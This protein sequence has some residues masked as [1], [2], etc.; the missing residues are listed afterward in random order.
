MS[1]K[2][3]PKLY[4]L[5]MKQEITMVIVVS[6]RIRMR[7]DFA[8]SVTVIHPGQVLFLKFDLCEVYDFDL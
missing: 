6:E 4:Y 7:S 1:L 3:K 2:L 5:L 8:F